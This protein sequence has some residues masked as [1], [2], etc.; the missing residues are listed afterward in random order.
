[1]YNDEIKVL[2]GFVFVRRIRNNEK[3]FYI[4]VKD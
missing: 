2:S 1:M 3:T 4:E